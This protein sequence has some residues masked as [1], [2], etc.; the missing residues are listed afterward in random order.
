MNVVIVL[1]MV[2]SFVFACSKSDDSPAVTAGKSVA[3]APKAVARF[4]SDKAPESYDFPIG[5]NFDDKIVLLGM[6][7]E[8]KKLKP[9]MPYSATFFFK[10]VGE[11]GGDYQFFGHLEPAAGATARARLDHEVLG[12]KYPTSQ[13]KVGQIITDKFRSRIPA[14]FPGGKQ[15]L[16]GGFFSGNKRLPVA[17]ADKARA[18]KHNRAKL[19]NITLGKGKKTDRSLDVYRTIDPIV[20]DGK[21][22][23]KSWDKA[24][25][26]GNFGTVG[27]DRI[28]DPMTYAKFLWD[29]TNL[30][31]AFVM[32]DTDIWTSYTKRDDP[33][34][35]EETAE[36]MIDADGSGETYFEFQVNAAN[37]AYDA[38]FTKRRE[39]RKLEWDSGMKHGVFVEGTLNKRDDTDKRW[40][41]EIAIPF[42]AISDAANKPP[43]SGDTWRLNVYRLEKPS[44]GGTQGMMWSP[45]LVGD[46]HVLD[47]FGTVV[48]KDIA[49]DK[50]PLPKKAIKAEY[51][52]NGRKMGERTQPAEPETQA[53]KP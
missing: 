35:K 21:L 37:A 46:F 4:V 33:L 41:V 25:S 51:D 17:T 42:T 2:A 28:V 26:T 23:E 22:D 47:R 14:D 32:D 50:R 10:V 53:V 1:I 9:G 39:G 12:G 19:A 36:I 30:Y 18:D 52:R 48:F 31:I 3:D 34:Y 11:V 43:K 6:N 15:I 13:W 27:G 45:T 38:S 5:I 7:I 49:V 8:P 44:K 16:W 29:D 20:L 24:V 40:T